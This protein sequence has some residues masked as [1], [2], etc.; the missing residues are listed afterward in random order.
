MIR[1]VVAY[2]DLLNLY[3]D[4]ANIRLLAARLQ[5]CGERVETASFSV[6]SYHDFSAA[7]LLYFGAG[8]EDRMLQAL[9]DFRRF[10]KELAAFIAN[11]GR[12]LATGNAGAIF[13]R[14]VEDT[15]PGK[16]GKA[17]GIGLFAADAQII[18]RRRYSELVCGSDICSEKLLGCVNSSV[19]FVRDEA[20]APMHRVLWD[21]EKRFAAGSGEGLSAAEGRLLATELTGPV[22]FRNPALL[23]A[24]AAQLCKKQLPVCEEQWYKQLQAG[25]AHALAVLPREA[26][27]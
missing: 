5:G 10:G 23:S 24:F 15:R 7:D 21:S 11:G 3:G 6:G 4:Y 27:K 19:N 16:E 25:Y 13:C 17:E 20:Q 14:S 26:T 9:R 8:T 12:L 18:R 1:I 2:P 22:F